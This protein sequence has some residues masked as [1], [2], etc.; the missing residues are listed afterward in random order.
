VSK[1]AMRSPK[2]PVGS[3]KMPALGA[4][5]EAEEAGAA[6]SK[7]SGAEDRENSS[8]P[9]TSEA[10]GLSSGLASR[11]SLLLLSLDPQAHQIRVACS[12][13]LS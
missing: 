12:R 10:E 8:A 3:T 4:E 6:V 11:G 1:T 9:E 7:E 2:K 5:E 13:S